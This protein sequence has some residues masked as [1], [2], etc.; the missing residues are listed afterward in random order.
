MESENK[1]I[2]DLFGIVFD[3]SHAEVGEPKRRKAKG[4]TAEE[5]AELGSAYLSEGDFQKAIEH[6]QRSIEQRDATDVQGRI[7]LAGAYEV[8]DMH[9]QAFRQY[10]R[11][12][13][14]KRDEPESHIGLSQIFKLHGR[15]RDSLQ[16]LSSALEINPENAF[17]HFKLAE[18]LREIGEYD[19]AIRS[20]QSAIVLA[21]TDSFYHYWIGDLMISLKRF[22][23]ALESLRA[24]I[25]LSPGDDY[26]Y[27]RASAAFWGAGKRQEAVKSV[28]LASDL[29]PDKDLYHGVLELLLSEMGL[30]EEADQEAERSAKMD[31]YDRDLLRRYASELE[32]VA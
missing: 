11:A 7:D 12:L 4:D 16:E 19:R 23:D 6:F 32:L 31:D 8:A 25:E 1:T 28:R 29:D 27:L 2:S 22:D 10:E 30:D 18:T 17:Y 13:R 21:P 15:F 3:P 9:P 5:S 26:L 20:M 24:A 14:T